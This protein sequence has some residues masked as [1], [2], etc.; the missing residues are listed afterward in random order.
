MIQDEQTHIFQAVADGRLD[1]QAVHSRILGRDED[2]FARQSAVP[3]R[4]PRLCLVPVYLR[5]V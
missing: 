5:G 3:D 2:I 1:V 4:D